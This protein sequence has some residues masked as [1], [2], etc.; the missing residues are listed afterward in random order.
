MMEETAA[1]GA[2]GD[3]DGSDEGKGRRFEFHISGCHHGRNSARNIHAKNGSVCIVRGRGGV[4]A[5]RNIPLAARGGG[6]YLGGVVKGAYW[7]RLIV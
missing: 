2:E 5:K 6:V 1:A 7:F 3:G 4:F